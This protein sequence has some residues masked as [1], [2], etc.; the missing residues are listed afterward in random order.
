MANIKRTSV[1]DREFKHT[2][3]VVRY[4]GTYLA[5]VKD[6]SDAQRMG[7]LKVWIPEFGSLADDKGGWVTVSYV[8]P[9]GGAT[10]PTIIG[11][12]HI[13]ADQT[14]T[15]Y[16]FWA[17]PPDLENQVV[18]TFI[19]GDPSRGVWLGCLYQQFM[20]H[21]VPGHAGGTSYQHPDKTVPVS[22][23][24][25]KTPESIRNDITR[26]ELTSSSEGISIQGLIDDGVRGVATAS[27]RREAPS[28]VFGISTPGPSVP[29]PSSETPPDVIP[30]VATTA[31]LPGDLGPNIPSSIPD[32]T[33]FAGAVPDVGAKIGQALAGVQSAIGSIT[34]PPISAGGGLPSLPS[35]PTPPA[36][37]TIPTV[38]VPGEGIELPSAADL[39]TVE[40]P[41]IPTEV[42]AGQQNETA[43]GTT[44]S[45]ASQRR[46]GGWQMYFDDKE[47]S[48]HMRIRSRNGSQLLIDDTNGLIYAINRAGTSWIQMDAEGNFDIFAAQSVS[49]R[50]HRDINLRADRDVNIEAGRNIRMK[51]TNDFIGSTDGSIGAEDEGDGGGNIR[52]EALKDM[53]TIVKNNHATQVTEGSMSTL[54][55]TGSRAATI[56]GSDQVDITGSYLLQADVDGGL[57]IGGNLVLSAG[58]F[59]VGSGNANLDLGGSLAVAG[60]L[61]AG[62]EGFASDFK[63]PNNGLEGHEHTYDSPVHK[64]PPAQT[65][66]HE[67]GGGSGSASGPTAG[68]ATA[69]EAFDPLAT[70]TK[71]NVLATFGDANNFERDTGEAL[72]VVGRFLTYEPCPEHIN[73]GST[74]TDS[75]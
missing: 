74:S 58:A 33:A 24:N 39:P 8:T 21:M 53:Q 19:N 23:F 55:S 20:N 14:Q 73:K 5:Y 41:E 9:F 43:G 38:A 16:G 37:P 7:R 27:A 31:S 67:G 26:P 11:N 12:N 59:G 52:I 70:T 64:G 47:S 65:S 36:L 63:S 51:A 57:N 44:A 15:S 4:E 35:L 34:L 72:T 6:N 17:I 62:G 32:P 50:S 54:I 69:V 29:A 49:V 28:C 66:K 25:K 3:R 48:E 45:T 40:A 60:D 18:V 10:D 13:P 42:A 75:T 1:A 68:E 61:I 22:E 30:G 2:G 46:K 71:T 56:E